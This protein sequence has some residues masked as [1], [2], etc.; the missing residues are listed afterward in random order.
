MSTPQEALA[1]YRKRGSVSLK[2]RHLE[3]MLFNVLATLEGFVDRIGPTPLRH[4]LSEK[5]V[6]MRAAIWEFDQSKEI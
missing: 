6:E 3:R 5:V 2:D 1:E 4:A